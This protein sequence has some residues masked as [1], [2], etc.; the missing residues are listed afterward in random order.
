MGNLKLQNNTLTDNVSLELYRGT[1]A[2]SWKIVNE[3]G[4]L[5]MRCNYDNGVV[6]YYSALTL[7]HTTGIITVN[8]GKLVT[9]TLDISSTSAVKHLHFSR[10]GWNYINAP[11]EGTLAFSFS[12]AA[13]MNTGTT[14]FYLNKD[15]L[16]PNA[17]DTYVLGSE[18]LKWANIYSTKFTGALEGNAD[19]A[20]QFASATTV[21]L[22]G[23]VTGTS[24]SSTRGWSIS[25]TIGANNHAHDA[26]ASWSNR[27]LSVSVGGGGAEATATIPA[28]LTGFTSITSNTLIAS[29]KMVIPVKASSYTSSTAGEI[30]IVA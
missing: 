29:T 3:N 14:Q 16:Y 1:N 23:D 8:E 13:D 18:S 2:A 28:T 17:S 25:T 9:P 30:W 11:A 4:K 7:D 22:T 6:N 15:G 26:S 12:D 5:S 24:N 19:T 27:T 21:V 10:V 20:S